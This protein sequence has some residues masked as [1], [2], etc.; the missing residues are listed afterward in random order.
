MLPL[1]AANANQLSDDIRAAV[2]RAE[3]DLDA[4]AGGSLK[5]SLPDNPLGASPVSS[6]GPI[7]AVGGND[8]EA[9]RESLRG[10]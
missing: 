5:V 3:G 4:V 1:S 8:R 10:L 9:T 7:Q 6:P 2:K